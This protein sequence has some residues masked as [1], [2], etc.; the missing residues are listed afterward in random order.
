M[1]HVNRYGHP[2]HGK[3]SING[4]KKEKIYKKKVDPEISRGAR[5]LHG[6]P[7]SKKHN[8]RSPVK[9][10]K[11]DVDT[12]VLKKVQGKSIFLNNNEKK[13]CGTHKLT[14]TPR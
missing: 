14:L 5:K 3:K 2:G 9:R 12:L 7:G 1:V 8:K 6:Y 10:K 11:T 13:N 4:E